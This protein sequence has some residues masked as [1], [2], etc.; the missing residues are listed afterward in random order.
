[1]R[2]PLEEIWAQT[3]AFFRERDPS[4]IGRAERDAKHKMALVFRW[5]L[6]QSSRWANAG[7]PTRQTDYQVWCGPAMGAFN[8]WARGSSRGDR[9]VSHFSPV[10]PNTLSRPASPPRARARRPRGGAL[11][12][13]LAAGRPLGREDLEARLPPTSPPPCPPPT[14]PPPLAPPPPRARC[15]R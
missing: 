5:Y 12:P 9:R 3:C 1:F 15:R 7:E 11:P 14:P 8:E 4:Q 13:P 10:P 2:A 6:A